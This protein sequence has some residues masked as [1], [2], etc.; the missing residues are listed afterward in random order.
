MAQINLFCLHEKSDRPK[1]WIWVK[2]KLKVLQ[3][4]Y[5]E[6]LKVT[7][8]QELNEI[9][10]KELKAGHSTIFKH[11]A[12]IS[13]STDTI[14]IPLP[15]VIEIDKLTNQK[16]HTQLVSS[17][18]ELYHPFGDQKIKPI[19]S[20]NDN[21]AKIVG[22]HAADGYL[23]KD[24]R[25]LAW[26]TVDERKDAIEALQRWIKEEFDLDVTIKRIEKDNAW[27]CNTKNKVFCRFLKN[28]MHMP[29]GKKAHTIREPTIIKQQSLVIRNSFARGVLIF[30]GCVKTNGI[31][32]LSSMSENL[33][34][35]IQLILKLNRIEVCINHN[36]KKQ[37]WILET[38]NSRDTQEI[39]KLLSFFEKSTYKYRRLY[40]FIDDRKYNIKELTE[41]FPENHLGKV[42]LKKVH[43]KAKSMKKFK[44]KQ[45]AKECNIAETT[46]YKYL[47]IL[48]KSEILTKETHQIKT[49]KNAYPDTWFKFNE[50]EVVV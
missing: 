37:S 16:Y 39:T 13:Y 20:I 44:A 45:L 2:I 17:I 22:A 31:V 48:H 33:I 28:I 38:Q 43:D 26:K 10:L 47:Y 15:I 21:V 7:N 42:S 25:T 34:K 40:F 11:L 4:A 23:Q 5:K 12:K 35:D 32:S 9:I 27:Q 8:K 41:L 14:N 19:V 3:E 36:K 24:K 49:H 1:E 46:T 6:I 30:D 50:S 29:T 18:V